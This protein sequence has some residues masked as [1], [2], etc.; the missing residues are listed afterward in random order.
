MM[1]PRF[2][3]AVSKLGVVQEEIQPLVLKD[4][5]A[6]ERTLSQLHEMLCGVVS[7]G[8]GKAA[9][10]DF[11]QIAGKTG[12]AYISEGGYQTVRNATFCGYFPAD[13]P[14]YSCIVVMKVPEGGGGGVCGPVIKEIAEKIYSN[15][16]SKQDVLMACDSVNMPMPSV[17]TGNLSEANNI[18]AAIGQRVPSIDIEDTD[19]IPGQMPDVTGMGAKDALYL[20]EEMGLDV[21]INGSGQV[22]GQ[23]I[24]IGHSIKKGEKVSLR[25]QL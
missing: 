13:K 20:L 11:V 12:T 2:V 21:E 7:T 6:S 14:K 15:N 9:M 25:L 17:K 8:T 1:K 19:V 22:V 16:I 10:S 23:S 18:L 3:K 5:I 4:A 24:P